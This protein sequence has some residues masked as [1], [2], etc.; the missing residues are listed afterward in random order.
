MQLQGTFLSTKVARRMLGAFILCA[1]A[2]VALLSFIAYR[3]VTTQLEQ[4]A[5][6]RLREDSKS[7][8]MM[9]L[10]RVALLGSELQ[11]DA[12]LVAAGNSVIAGD[13]DGSAGSAPRFRALSIEQDGQARLVAGQSRHQLPSPST[14]QVAHLARG[15]TALV[16]QR[17][18]SDLVIYLVRQI[19]LASGET[20]RL[21]AE[22]KPEQLWGDPASGRITPL[23]TSLCLLDSART[24]LACESK[25]AVAALPGVQPS[26][27][28]FQYEQPNGAFLAGYWTVFLGYEYAAPSWFIILSRSQDGVLEPLASFRHTFVLVVL[29]ALVVVFL[30][31]HVQIRLTMTPLDLL[32]AGTRRIALGDFSHPVRVTSGD[33]FQALGASFNQMAAEL[34]RRLEQLDALSWGALTALAK[35]IDAVSPWTA[36]HSE[37]VTQGA[38]EIGRRLGLSQTDLDLLHRGG[39]LHDMGKVGVPPAILDKP[40]ALTPDEREIVERHT[41]LGAQILE[42]I[43]AFRPLIPLVLHHHEFLDG[44]GYP[45]HLSG[46]QIPLLVRI[47][48]VSDV[49]DAL[50]SDRPYRAAWPKEKAIAFLQEGAGRRFDP[51]V[52]KA[53]TAAV[54]EGWE[55]TLTPGSQLSHRKPPTRGGLTADEGW[56][57]PS[58]EAQTVT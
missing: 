22:A 7:V 41:T 40:G 38:L 17:V 46:D 18:D 26:T 27:G 54:A 31:G 21:W 33:E 1:L 57:V 15:G 53:F 42:P 24:P 30:L 39:L 16:T 20:A 37:R 50:A 8:G 34:A 58:L 49:Y 13:V 14:R 45:R 10:G 23:G 2:P 4:Q 35:A 28:T 19:R 56:K 55:P 12:A 51:K 11:Q 36:G 52:V 47:L 3:S 44:T 25:D 48:T 9:L 32:H 29:I 43:T 6:D 5:N